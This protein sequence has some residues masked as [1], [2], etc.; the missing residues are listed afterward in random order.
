MLNFLFE[1][2]EVHEVLLYRSS[3]SIYSFRNFWWEI[4]SCENV[5]FEEKTRD[6]Y[7]C[8]GQM[9]SLNAEMARV[10]NVEHGN[11]VC[12]YHWYT[13]RTTNNIRPYPLPSHPRAMNP[14]LIPAKLFQVFDEVGKACLS[15]ESERGCARESCTGKLFFRKGREP[16]S[17]DTMGHSI[18]HLHPPYWRSLYFTPSEK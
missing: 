4:A 17:E 18:F 9:I 11:F 15:I 6:K 8:R 14:T 10:A 7:V 5:F 2:R 12:E 16:V 13:L 1:V 3:V